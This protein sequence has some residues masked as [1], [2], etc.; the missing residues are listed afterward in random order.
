MLDRFRTVSELVR[1]R[2]DLIPK[3]MFEPATIA[4]AQ[5]QAK[6]AQSIALPSIL[7]HYRT[8]T[9]PLTAKLLA[10]DALGVGQVSRYL[11]AF[12]Q[13]SAVSDL[14]AQ[15]LRVDR[16]FLAAT[17]A[18]SLSAVPTF[19]T[20]AG[21]RSFLD[22]AGLG[23]PRWPKVRLLTVAEKRRRFKARLQRKAEPV[24]V[25]KAKSLVHRYE[26][27][28]REILDAVMADAYGEDWAKARLPLCGC[29]DLLGRWRK[30]GGDVLDHADYAHYARIM[31]HPEHFSAVFEAGFDDPQALA[32]LLEDAGRLRAASHHARAFTPE[33]LRDLRVT[34][35][36][37]EAGL[38]AFTADYE[39]ETWH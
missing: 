37:I 9:E 16:E 32:A 26:L 33:D 4:F 2:D 1:V 27:T 34:W 18:F 38:L 23:L 13:A 7:E 15:S 20:L 30:R 22:A 24:H 3:V 19:E 35:R 31:S 10:L 17:R 5:E 29:N 25:K 6:L 11:E 8:A 21:Y 12:S 28:L 14:I 39:L 36:T